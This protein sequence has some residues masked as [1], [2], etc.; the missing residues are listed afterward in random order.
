MSILEEGVEL[1][2]GEVMGMMNILKGTQDKIAFWMISG[3]HKHLDPQI[4]TITSL[5]AQLTTFLLLECDAML[6]PRSIICL[7]TCRISLLEFI[8]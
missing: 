1:P 2:S 5:P 4:L 8:E 7:E 6:L 3:N